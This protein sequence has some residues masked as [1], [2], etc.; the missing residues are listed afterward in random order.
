MDLGRLARITEHRSRRS[1]SWDRSG[2]NSDYVADLAPGASAVLL[3]CAGPG[4]VTH[5]WMTYFEYPG[6]TTVLRDLVVRM[7]WDGA[8]VPAVEV[9]LGD[10]FGAGHALPPG[11][12]WRRGFTLVS[13]PVTVGMNERSFNCYWPMPF[14]AGTRIELYNSG[15]RSLRQLYFHVDHELG[16]QDARDGRFHAAFRQERALA[17]QGWINRGGAG[18]LVLLDAAGRGQYV[19]CLL[20]VDNRTPG[21]FGEGDD[22]I[23]IDH[24]PAPTINGTGTEDYFNNAWCYDK[25]FSYPWFGCPLI[26]QRA[27]G[28]AFYT[29]YRFHGPDP[30]RFA[31]HIRVTLEHVWGD[32]LDDLAGG[33]GMNGF[34]ATVFWYQE[35][36]VER[37]AGLPAGA[38]RLPVRHAGIAGD[39]AAPALNVPAMEV[40]LRRAGVAVETVFRVPGWAQG[41][42]WL[43]GGGGLRVR[44]GG[45]A[46]AVPLAL[47]GAGRYRVEVQPIPALC[48]AGA[49]FA[50]AG[51]AAV[52]PREE[53]LA[54]QADAAWIALG[55]V[56]TADGAAVMTVTADDGI[57]FQG[58]RAT[59]VV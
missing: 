19:G 7:T 6:H 51:G 42:E 50:V 57:A 24:D 27:D 8:A 18:N 33:P 17:S 59:R 15:E 40:G 53:A 31:E 14:A 48:D 30:I 1:S 25:P 4:R 58:I 9:P 47:D 5:I 34:A 10:F 35:R 43:R 54:R 22:M 36:P 3:D 26:D 23:F 49:R 32:P 13:A 16:P 37:R 29:M 56:A 2:G 44:C 38:D 39:E 52:A 46:I 28:G 45:R 12:Y 41:Q 20:Y 55:E 11:Y 21:W